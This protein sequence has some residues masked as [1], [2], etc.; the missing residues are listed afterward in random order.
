MRVF[1]LRK[2]VALALALL[3]TASASYAQ[4]ASD[5]AARHDA[6]HDAVRAFADEYWDFYQRN[7]PESA[8]YYGAYRYNAKLKDY[9]LA[10]WHAQEA[11]T[12]ALLAR[13]RALDAS[14]LPEADQLDKLLLER[15][16]ADRL[17]S[18]RLKNYEMPV[19]QFGGI[20]IQLAQLPS[21]IPVDSV[22][23]YEDYV[24]RLNQVAHQFDQVMA[25]M[26]QGRKDGL[27]PPQLM[28]ELSAQQ[29]QA[30]ADKKG[31]DS[32]FAEP[33]TRMPASFTAAER[34][35]LT[36]Q[37]LRAIDT[38]VRPAYR[39][40]QVFITKDYA[41]YGRTDPGLWALPDGDAR[42]RFAIHTETTSNMTPEQ[43]HQLGLAQ[44]AD[45]EAQIDALGKSAGYADGKS[46]RAA[47]NADPKLVPASRQQIVDE[48][49]HYIAQMKPHLPELFGLL[50]KADVVVKPVPDY[51]EKDSSTQY[52]P[53][54]ADGSRAGMVQVNTYDYQH[55]NMLSDEATAYHEGIPGHHMQ[56]SIAQELPGIHPFHRALTDEYNAYIE[57]WAL[58]SER[59][60]KEVGFYQDPASDLGRL[61]NELFRAVRLVVDTGV[62][63]KHWSRQ[64][65]LDYAHEHLY[66]DW[67][68]EIDRYIADPAQALGYKIGQLKILEL[69]K[70][71]QDQLGDK[72]DVRAFHDEIL[73]AG[74]LPLDVLDR[75]LRDWVASNKQAH[76]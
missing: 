52:Q 50:P 44:V 26:Q 48:Y 65:M 63:Y 2:P 73:N 55:Q 35:R 74:P 60:G 39:K 9:S 47:V 69:R 61:E 1:A 3:F 32:P 20:Q 71:A 19:D 59:L 54:T 14:G 58:Y 41:P 22:H 72:F 70:Y 37:I 4:S 34:K 23:H 68:S 13:V 46:F 6:R 49:A 51:M 62:H 66:G 11:E 29:C 7:S 17:E 16:L 33:I 8:T 27:M 31:M 40:L 53:G 12:A 21:A 76:G 10:H 24:A 67:T 15:T 18:L 38:K 28:L 5:Q 30:I 64:Q 43:I 25:V 36:A 57:G 75:R 45:I 42:Y 56:I